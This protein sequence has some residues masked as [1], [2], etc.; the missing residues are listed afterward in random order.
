MQY[1]LYTDE[2]T[3]RGPYFSTFYGGVLV[4]STHLREVAERLRACK[5]A[6]GMHGEVKWQKVKQWNLTEYQALVD[7]F[8]ELISEDRVKVR[9]MF[10][11]NAFVP[12]NLTKEQRESQY[13]LLYYQFIK[14]AFGLKYHDDAGP[15][16]LRI[17][18]DQMPDTAEKNERFRGF[19]AA[20]AHSPD[21]R[22][23][24]ITI[25]PQDVT[26][27]DSQHHLLP[28]F[29]DIVLGA[30]QFRLNDLHKRKPEGAKLRGKTTRAKEKLYKH[31]NAHLQVIRPRFNIGID[32]G[33]D[34][35]LTNHWHHS[36]R[37]WRFVP[38]ARKVDESFYKP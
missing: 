32:T 30:M 8:F 34:D 13:H 15:I 29:L 33:L 37:H 22:H 27:V 14:H 7:C 21:F 24:G 28:Q 23:A 17:Y 16:S 31:I 12:T 38:K 3:K 36:Y 11:Q 10:S 6:V 2:S 26:E 20:L 5:E 4:R 1:I 35:D 9:I 18:L 19:V 25:D